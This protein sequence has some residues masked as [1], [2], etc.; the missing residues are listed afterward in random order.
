MKPLFILLIIF[1]I[2]TTISKIFYHQWNSVFA[3]N[4]A[5]SIMLL[6]T[7]IGHFAFSRGVIMMLPQVIPFKKQIIFSTGFIEILAAVGLLIISF[8]H[9]T[10][11][12]LIIFF[13]LILPANI[14]AAFK[15][16]DYQKGNY[17]GGGI[18][19]LW[20]RV[21]LQVL[22]IAWVCYFGIFAN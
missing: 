1:G 3:G 20:F 15:K 11:V 12:L 10:S 9:L 19:Y 14:Y 7:A 21:P 5:M 17:E 6:F 22:F 8:R 13:A 18:N 2:V 16:I 4:L